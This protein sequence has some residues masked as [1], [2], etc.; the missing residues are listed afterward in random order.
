MPGVC[1]I[2]SHDA[3]MLRLYKASQGK[4]SQLFIFKPHFSNGFQEQYKISEYAI[5]KCLGRKW[6]KHHTQ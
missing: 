5:T 2:V 4:K 6:I 1:H 3:I